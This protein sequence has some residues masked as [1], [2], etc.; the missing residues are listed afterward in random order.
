VAWDQDPSSP[1]LSQWERALGTRISVVSEKD[2][3]L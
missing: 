3:P 1:A 2:L